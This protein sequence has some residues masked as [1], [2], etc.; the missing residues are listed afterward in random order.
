MCHGTG[1]VRGRRFAT[2][3][4]ARCRRSATCGL[5][6]VPRSRVLAGRSTRC[7]PSSTRST[8]DRD[9]LPYEIDGLVVKVNDLS[10]QR[11]LGEVSRSPRWA[12]A[13][14]F[15]ARQATTRILDIVPSVGRTG[16]LTPVAVLEPVAVGGVTVRN[17]SLHNMDEIERKD[18]RIGDTVL[19]ERAGDVIPYVVKVLTERRTGEEKRFRMPAKCPV[20][21]AEVVRARGRGRVPLH[22]R[23]AARRS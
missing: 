6:P 16:V 8:R 15:K 23:L 2:R 18:V 12:V 20:C 21:G 3:L 14:K 7:S 11:R 10:L 1:E 5:R 4:R 22:R 9:A 13:Y 17:A 19:L